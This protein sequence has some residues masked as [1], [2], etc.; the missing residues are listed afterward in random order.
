MA[1]IAHVGLG[2]NF[3]WEISATLPTPKSIPTKH[4][5]A[6]DEY[7]VLKEL[8]VISLATPTVSPYAVPVI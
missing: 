8:S 1:A 5:A 6:D 7:I 3:I 4:V 2:A